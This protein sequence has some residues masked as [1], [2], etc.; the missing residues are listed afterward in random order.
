[1]GIQNYIPPFIKPS[2]QQSAQMPSIYKKGNHCGKF[3]MECRVYNE[4]P[5]KSGSINWF[6]FSH[7]LPGDGVCVF[8]NHTQ[9][10]EH[11]LIENNITPVKEGDHVVAFDPMLLKVVTTGESRLE[12]IERMEQALRRCNIF[13]IP[14]NIQFLVNALRMKKFREYGADSQTIAEEKDALLKDIEL[15]PFE[16]CN[17]IASYVFHTKKLNHCFLFL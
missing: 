6:M 1:M 15:T 17:S 12:V 3:S 16:M 13:G 9:D 11:T 4:D 5:K 8:K 14:T 10:S 2:H 7:F